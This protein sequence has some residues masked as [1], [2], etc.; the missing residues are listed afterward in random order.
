M[1]KPLHHLLRRG[2]FVSHREFG[3]FLDKFEKGAPVYLYTGRGPSSESLHL[4]HLL[5]FIV[6]KYLQ[7]VFRCPTFIQLTDDEKFFYQKED[8]GEPLEKF[9]GYA[10]EN[11]K[12]I[13]ACGFDPELTFI[14]RNSDYMG[15]LYPNVVKLQKALTYNQVKGI[16]GL[17]G[18]ENIGKSA[19]PPI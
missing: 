17:T 8:A 3:V 15:Y 10:I 5:P 4:G 19:F 16:F 9:Q 1:G 7:D 18:S 11:A 12:D 6:T 13:I 14:F 2:I